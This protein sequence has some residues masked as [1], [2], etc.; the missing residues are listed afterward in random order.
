MVVVDATSP[1][2]P[3]I[4]WGLPV[5]IPWRVLADLFGVTDPTVVVA[6]NGVVLHAPGQLDLGRTTRLASKAQRR[7]LRALYPTCAIPGCGVRFRY[8]QPHHVIW[9][10]HGGPT[11]FANLQPLCDKHHHCVH[12]RGWRLRLG[13]NR[14]LDVILP[15]GQVMSTGPPRRQAA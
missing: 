1:A 4:D 2:G 6:R 15:D 12:D 11:D 3:V 13:P 9:W 14:E 8:T 5:E 7:A 10:E